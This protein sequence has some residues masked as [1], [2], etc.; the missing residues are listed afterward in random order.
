MNMYERVSTSSGI[1]IFMFLFFLTSN[2]KTELILQLVET[3][4]KYKGTAKLIDFFIKD[5]A[6]LVLQTHSRI[7][8]YV[9]ANFMVARAWIIRTEI[10][11]GT[12]TAG[13]LATTK[14]NPHQR[15]TFGP[16][17]LNTGS[18]SNI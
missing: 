15:D 16:A 7:F 9:F 11:D 14:A 2:D 3:W 12:S 13:R 17:A 8:I 5:N 18:P 10:N 6:H 1:W 4:K